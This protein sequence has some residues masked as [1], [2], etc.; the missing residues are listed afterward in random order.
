MKFTPSYQVLDSPPEPALRELG[1]RQD[2]PAKPGDGGSHWVI[3][4]QS[5]THHCA[6]GCSETFAI[7]LYSPVPKARCCTTMSIPFPYQR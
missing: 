2:A 6:C 1:V 7:G 4:S 5:A 3:G